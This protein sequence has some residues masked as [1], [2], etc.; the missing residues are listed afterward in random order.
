MIA[1]LKGKIILKKD[2]YVIVNTGAIGYQVWLNEKALAVVK[3]D[4]E[5]EFYT[6]LYSR[7]DSQELYG[8]LS[9]PELELFKNLLSI[10]GVGPKSALATLAVASV[11]DIMQAVLTEDP[12]ILQSV[13]GIGKKTAERIILELKNKIEKL[14]GKLSADGV[15][16]A[17]KDLEIIEALENLGYHRQEVLQLDI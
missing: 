5:A 15:S 17:P 1:Y 6:H 10:S 16:A 13:S 4:E 8:F 2:K 12:N 11:S 14:S 9:L 3:E 7:E